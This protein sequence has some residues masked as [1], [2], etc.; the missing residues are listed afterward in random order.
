ML[1]LLFFLASGSAAGQ[2]Y[3]GG[4]AGIAT[5]SGDGAASVTSTAA[6]TAQYQP[7]IGLAAQAFTGRTI[8][9][10]LA[11]QAAF[12]WNRNQLTFVGLDNSAAAFSFEQQR[13]SQQFTLGLDGLIYFR[14]RGERLRPY[15][16][17]GAGW[18]RASSSAAALLNASGTPP[19]P[20]AQFAAHKPY[21]RTAVGLDVTLKSRWRFR[22]TFWETV[23]TNPFGAELRP[24][25]RA[26]LLNFH[27]Q[28]GLL[29]EF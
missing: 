16:S 14:K 6:A 24:Q 11:A 15:V 23:C 12:S 22:Y 21:W 26:L 20:A 5:L 2:W 4:S 13:R 8:G 29:R 19:L 1:L 18:L 27:N 17:G 7:R 25:G 9:N 28:F 10:Y 3:A